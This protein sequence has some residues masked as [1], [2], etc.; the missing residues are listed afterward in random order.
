MGIGPFHTL[1]VPGLV[2][3][4][5]ETFLRVRNHFLLKG[6]VSVLTYPYASFD[7]ERM[8][9]TF[10]SFLETCRRTRKKPILVGVSVGGGFLL[11]HL[12]RSKER[13]K[14]L[15]PAAIVLVSPL[16][17]PQ[18]L[19]PVLRRLWNPIV[20][21]EGNSTQALEKG[22]NFFRLLASKS[23]RSSSPA[24]AW[25][26]I[27]MT[28]TP[29]GLEELRDAPVRARIEKTLQSVPA[30][31]AIARCLALKAMRGLD[32]AVGA[33]T[34]AP[35]LILWGSRERHTLDID[36]PGTSVLCRPD[37]AEKFFP[38]AQVQWVY[39]RR[40]ESVPHASLL[41]HDKAFAPLLKQFLAR[42]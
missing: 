4:G 40:G 2:P 8:M 29:Q 17:C 37:L 38:E 22:R 39:G 6:D 10:D 13:G 36:G 20:A 1:M 28:F 3:D 12:R 42:V 18:D 7:A 23:A 32:P 16:S 30:E 9:E 41:K 11:E 34:Q 27:L 19:A 14:A 24:P 15:E 5:E 31:G 35:T 33:L 25:A 21:S 26:K